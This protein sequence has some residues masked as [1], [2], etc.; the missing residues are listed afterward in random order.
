MA[1]V[2][3]DSDFIHIY[4]G[5]Q[6]SPRGY[7][8]V[9]P[10]G[11]NRANVGLGIV[12]GEK[13]PKF[14]LKQFIEMHPEIKKGS[15]IEVNAGCVP[16]GGMVENMVA[17]GFMVCG[18]AANHVNPIHGGGIKEA[19]ISGIMAADTITECMKTNDF[20]EKALSQFNTSWWEMRG[21]MLRNVEKL[22]EVTEKLSDDDLN[23]LQEALKPEDV[24]DF[25]RGAKLS[26]LAKVL[27]RKPSLMMLAKHLL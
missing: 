13:T 6:I 8:W 12:P 5:N 18:E 1:N 16:V 25:A 26:T 9:F 24:I 15:I 21:N 4:L 2:D 19:V 3:M 17:N 14:Y 22:R 7:C 11:E 10:K 27:M 20:S 23:D